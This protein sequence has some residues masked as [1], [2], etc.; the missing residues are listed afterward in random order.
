[1]TETATT[2]Y[3]AVEVLEALGDHIE[4]GEGWYEF[5]TYNPAGTTR[6][7]RYLDIKV[8]LRGTEVPVR[9]VERTGGMDE[10]S[11]ASVIIEVGSQFFKKSGY[12]ASHYGHD[13]DGDFLEV[14][15][16]EKTVV[17]YEA[18]QG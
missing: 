4:N 8:V 18:V 12:Y 1:M 7:D 17:V 16:V 3:T 5:R 15:P 2:D 10:G 14:K 6:E 11:N 13:W 9:E